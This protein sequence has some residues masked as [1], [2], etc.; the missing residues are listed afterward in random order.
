MP[1]GIIGSLAI[2]MVLYI[3]VSIVMIGL[4]PYTDLK[5]APAPIA[6]A[7]NAAYKQAQNSALGPIFA[8]F[9]MIIKVGAILGLSSTMVVMVM[10]QPRVFYSMSKDGL[11]PKWAAK[12]HPRFRT[13][14]ITTIITGAIVAIMAGFVPISLLG[15][16]VSIGTLFAFVI[17]SLG[18][19]VMRSTNPN[20]RRP[21]RVPL[22]PAIPIAAAV[23]S[24]YLMNGLPL[25]TWLRLILWMSIG[26]LIYFAYSYKHSNLAFIGS[27]SNA[28]SLSDN[29]A[30]KAALSPIIG[31][32]IV[33]GLTIWMF[34]FTDESPTARVIETAIRLF[35]WITVGVMVYFLTYGKKALVGEERNMQVARI[36]LAASVVNILVWAGVTYWFFVHYAEL[37]HK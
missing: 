18:V 35:V 19:I 21:F 12:V 4:V 17:V 32:L 13:P 22:S 28:E 30:Y 25:D 29:S 5:E 2:C 24:A 33:I 1:I 14:Y 23:A 9:P 26:L 3:L 15:E 10:G 11:L 36:G 27:N 8:A 20:L 7:I 34:A 16:L 6:V 31:V 37:H